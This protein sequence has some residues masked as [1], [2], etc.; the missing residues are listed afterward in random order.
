M[1]ILDRIG[2]VP[3]GLGVKAPCLVATTA[4]ITLSGLQTIDAVAVPANARVLVKDQADGRQ[5]G[6]YQASTGLWSRPNDCHGNEELIGGTL[7][8]VLSGAAG[9]GRI[10]FLTS[11][12]DPVVIGTSVLTFVESTI[13]AATQL[14]AASTTSLAIGTGSKTF[15]IPAGK[16]FLANEWVL[17]TSNADPSNAMFGQ[18]TSYAGTSL[19]LNVVATGGSGTHADW[20]LGLSNSAATAGRQPPVGTGNVTGPGSAVSGHLAQFADA[21]GKVLADSNLVLPTGALIGVDATLK[22]D[23]KLLYWD[24]AATTHKY[25]WASPAD[26]TADLRD[27]LD[28][29][30]GAG[31]WAFR[32]APHAGSDCLAAMHAALDALRS[33]YGYGK[34][35][36]TGDGIFRFSGGIDPDKL[37]GMMIEGVNQSSSQMVFDCSTGIAFRFT[38][39]GGFQGG[40]LRNLY[41]YIEDG[42]P[43]STLQGILMGGDV[44]NQPDVAF[45]ENL[46][47]QSLGNSLWYNGFVAD[48]T[49]R[50]SPQGIRD[51]TLKNVNLFSCRN[52]GASFSNCV[53]WL[54]D[55]LGVYV[56]SG[57][58]AD[59]FITG[60]GTGTTNSTQI[61][62][63]RFSVA[64]Q[65]RLNNCSRVWINGVAAGITTDSTATYMSGINEG[66]TLTG[67]FGAHSSVTAL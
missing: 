20:T 46:D 47:F 22:V 33:R 44:S 59:C 51:C 14:S 64:G 37:K 39:A 45:F 6:V 32:N 3:E 10:F 56:G 17:A 58:G 55:D 38:G 66:S 19:V 49:A 1:T 31:G 67:S 5:N 18:I 43:T 52:I 34:V 4:A 15:T 25:A 42:A 23:G 40:G 48:G 13:L 24:A 16:G 11:Q 29:Q 41:V 62:L 21:T 60:N 28:M 50:T 53:Q 35:R 9:G 57:S 12:D 27:F 54:I 65:L 63:R 8:S 61:D 7:V 36:V 2:N 26:S 30:Y